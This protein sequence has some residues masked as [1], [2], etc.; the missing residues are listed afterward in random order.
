MLAAL[1]LFAKNSPAKG[2]IL[3]RAGGAGFYIDYYCPRRPKP[4]TA[5]SVLSE[6]KSRSFNQHEMRCDGCLAFFYF[7]CRFNMR[8]T[9]CSRST[10]GWAF[11]FA[12]ILPYL[13]VWNR[14]SRSAVW[15]CSNHLYGT[16][17]ACAC[18]WTDAWQTFRKR[19]REQIQRHP[20]FSHPQNLVWVTG[21]MVKIVDSKHKK[22]QIPSGDFY[23]YFRPPQLGFW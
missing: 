20:A 19:N 11:F 18:A 13:L 12:Y 9:P 1:R 7:V 4:H 6:C 16:V 2:C 15:R 10:N 22:K 23:V 14:Y 17:N 21:L 8:S 3:L 5:P